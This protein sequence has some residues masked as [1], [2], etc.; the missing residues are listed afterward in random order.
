M[1]PRILT[2]EQEKS[3]W[4][5]VAVAG[6]L[7]TEPG[8]VIDSARQ[9]VARWRGT[10]RPDG[11]AEESLREWSRL[12]D[13]DLGDLVDVLTSR[14]EEACELR[15]NSPFTGVL[16]PAQRSAVTRS[17]AAAHRDRGRAVAG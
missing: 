6:V 5:H 4:L 2:P 3:L 16:T 8:R 7:V 9:T 17:Y 13:G 1:G 15:P 10:Q 12:L 14:S 11:R